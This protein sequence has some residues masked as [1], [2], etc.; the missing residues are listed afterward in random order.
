[1]VYDSD[2]TKPTRERCGIK[3]KTCAAL[4]E[5]LSCLEVKLTL[6]FL[7]GRSGRV[8]KGSGA[9]EERGRREDVS[10]KDEMR[11]GRFNE[12][13]ETEERNKLRRGREKETKVQEREK[14]RR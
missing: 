7:T 1:M 2:S 8:D 10:R 4:D 5:T 12:D 3:A 11:K 13:R 6:L 14:R 9:E